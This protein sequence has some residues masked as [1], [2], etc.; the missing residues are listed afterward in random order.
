MFG[1]QKIERLR[2]KL[3]E[4]ID[5]YGINSNETAE[6]SK[7]IDKEID[8]YYNEENKKEYPEWSNTPMYFEESYK[9]LKKVT[10]EFGEFPTVGG[11]NKYAKEYNLFSAVSIEYIT[12]LDWN[13]LRVKVK[14][15]VFAEK[16]KNK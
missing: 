11:W 8:K 7:K 9:L 14:K 4:A 16:K 2:E 3:H 15:E 12:G 1:I 6:I 13:H 5:K 10:K